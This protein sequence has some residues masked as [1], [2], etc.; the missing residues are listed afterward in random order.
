MDVSLLTLV[1]DRLV[2]GSVAMTPAALKHA[3]SKH[4]GVGSEGF[5]PH[6][7]CSA[8]AQPHPARPAAAPRQSRAPRSAPAAT[9]TGCLRPLSWAK[10]REGSPRETFW[11]F[12][13]NELY[14]TD[15]G[16]LVRRHSPSSRG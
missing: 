3:Q 10:I 6:K 14:L 16:S 8:L 1:L 2:P 13:S 4:S 9:E 7:V 15:L 5:T 12:R 11:S